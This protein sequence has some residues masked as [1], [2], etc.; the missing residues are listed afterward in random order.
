MG[1][2]RPLRRFDGLRRRVQRTRNEAAALGLAA[3][4]ART[5]WY[6]KLV[7]GLTVGLAAS[8]V[9]P[10]PDFVPVLGYVDDAVFIPAGAYLAWRLTPEE[11]RADARERAAEL[12]PGRLGWFAAVLVV[13]GWLLVGFV[14]VRAALRVA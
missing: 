2:D 9:D 10:I 12:E 13:L 4:D 7:A 6:A 1:A 8:P 14:V 11:V 5:P 3:R